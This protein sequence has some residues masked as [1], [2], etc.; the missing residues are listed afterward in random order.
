MSKLIDRLF[1]FSAEKNHQL[2]KERGLSFEDVIWA[3]YDG[4][5]LDTIEHP[6]QIKYPGQR[7]YIVNLN[8][9]VCMVPFVRQNE[10]SVFLKTVIP[11]RKLTKKYLGGHHV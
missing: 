11:S 4:K 7:I 2:I 5:L 6:D 3:L 1:D 10:Y 9:Y 8:G